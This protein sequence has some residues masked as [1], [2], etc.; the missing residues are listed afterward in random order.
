MK[1]LPTKYRDLQSDWFGKRGISWHVSVVAR[2]VDEKL[3][4]RAFVHMIE[5]CLQDTSAVVRIHEHTLRTLKTEHPEITLC[6][7]PPGQCWMLSQFSVV[8]NM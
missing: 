8:G 4:S 7:P 3:Q 5:S 1:F 6:L 2:K